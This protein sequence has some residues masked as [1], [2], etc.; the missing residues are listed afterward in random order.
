MVPPGGAKGQLKLP[1]QTPAFAQISGKPVESWE[2]WF[3]VPPGQ[4]HPSV[5]PFWASAVAQAGCPTP[6]RS[7]HHSR[8]A[9]RSEVFS[10]KG[11]GPFP[12]SSPAAGLTTCPQP[13]S[14]P[15]VPLLYALPRYPPARRPVPTTGFLPADLSQPQLEWHGTPS[16]SLTFPVWSL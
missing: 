7:F 1:H 11:P 16:C 4:R 13:A 6:S 15:Q 14:P 3:S 12:S 8:E 10:C 9:Q 5:R 2:S